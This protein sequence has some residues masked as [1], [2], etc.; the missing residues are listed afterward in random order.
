MSASVT[1]SRRVF[2]KVTP[3]SEQVVVVVVVQGKEEQFEVVVE[4]KSV[5]RQ[6]VEH[7]ADKI[8]LCLSHLV[9]RVEIN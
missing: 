4:G 3:K 7:C 6:K 8:L 1:D 5:E 2:S 9:A